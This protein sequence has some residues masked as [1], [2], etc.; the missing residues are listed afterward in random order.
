MKK[1]FTGAWQ[2]NNADLNQALTKLAK[3]AEIDFEI[4]I[5]IDKMLKETNYRELVLSELS[6]LGHDELNTIIHWLNSPAASEQ[7]PTATTSK[8]P[9]LLSAI[10]CIAVVISVVFF[11]LPQQQQLETI[12]QQTPANTVK[13]VATQPAVAPQDT[14][15][16]KPEITEKTKQ[17]LLFRL[18]GSNTIGEKLAPALLE[19]YLKQQGIIDFTWIQGDSPVERQLSYQQG[20]T[21]YFIELHAHGSS[22]AFA[23][24]SMDKADI[25]MASRR[26]KAKEI[27]ELQAKLG[28]LNSVGNEHIIGLDG[29]AVIVNQNNPIKQL[30]SATLAK[31][32]SGEINNWSQLGGQDQAI[33]IFSRDKHSGTWDTF[34][35]LVLKK[36]NKKLASNAVRLESS[37]EL[38]TRVSQN[39]GAIG[40]I[41]LNYVLH[42]KALAISAAKNTAAIFPT[43]FTIGTEDYALARRLYFYTP[44]SASNTVKSFAQ[45]AI[46]AQGQDIVAATGLI[47]QNIK[48]EETYPRN[49]APERYNYYVKNGK[50][51]SLN[52]RFDYATKDLDNKGKRDLERLVSFM[53]QHQG[54]R[55][56][57]LGFSDSVG[58]QLKNQ[59]L[60]LSRAKSVELEL[61]SRGI[62][63][64]AVEGLGEAL[65]IANNNTE[66]GRKRN[67]RVEVWLL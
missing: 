11:F 66:A 56:A 36:H 29:L 26:I 47:S 51:L 12:A 61:T 28:T 62:P 58:A 59:N 57:L 52:F 63:V 18:H 5:S 64:M 39:E 33:T 40:F 65:P 45:Y 44:T 9:L 38:S 19:G 34:K 10:A 50:R 16:K 49:D 31:V 25:G 53:E 6:Q 7:S 35:N 67:R 4:E 55:I 46:S 13:T 15:I 42:N 8:L 30:S 54:R 48:L 27:T 37:S 1:V 17:K 2:A 60:S 3:I 22:T 14:A 23:D 21:N 32:F 20:N 41:G 43:R 24:L